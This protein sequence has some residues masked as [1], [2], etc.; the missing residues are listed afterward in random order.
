MTKH[1]IKVLSIEFCTIKEKQGKKE[2][3]SF[4]KNVFITQKKISNDAN[5]SSI[6]KDFLKIQI[7]NY[8]TECT[9]AA[10]IRSKVKGQ[11]Y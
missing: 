7:D 6:E 9:R 5:A 2:I 4:W 3:L 8:Y 1:Y 11:I 10:K